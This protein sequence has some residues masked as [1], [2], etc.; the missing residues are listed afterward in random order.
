[1]VPGWQDG[2]EKGT[3]DFVTL[4]ESRL[5]GAGED[6]EDEDE[7]DEEE[8]DEDG[9]GTKKTPQFHFAML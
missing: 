4:L 2:F 6:D 8:D 3:Q 5:T 7:E 9:L 1:M